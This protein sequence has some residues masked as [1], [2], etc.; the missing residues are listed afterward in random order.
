MSAG[1]YH[2]AEEASK[3]SVEMK[4]EQVEMVDWSSGSEDPS[5]PIWRISIDGYCAD[6]STETAAQ[7]FAKAI[8]RLR[9]SEELSEHVKA[10]EEACNHCRA[11]LAGYVSIQSAIDKLDMLR[12]GPP[13]CLQHG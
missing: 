10:L 7:N 6:F 12:A 2:I 13:A 3:A 1:P 4:V 9:V 11:A 5:E 8:M